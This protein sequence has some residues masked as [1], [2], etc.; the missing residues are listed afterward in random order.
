M[1]QNHL[2]QRTMWG[3]FDGCRACRA[4]MIMVAEVAA[5]TSGSTPISSISGP[6]MMPPPTPNMPVS[7]NAGFGVDDIPDWVPSLFTA[8][9]LAQ[10]EAL[11]ATRPARLHTAG[12][13]IV[14][15]LVH[16]TCNGV[17]TTCVSERASRVLP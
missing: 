5:A 6:L 15:C 10:H 17:Q 2:Q 14:F 12:Y 9:R 3:V 11:P 16:A 4:H 7:T 8:E 13:T 1:G